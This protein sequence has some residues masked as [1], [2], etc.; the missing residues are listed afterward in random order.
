MP[1]KVVD[2][3]ET[4]S[5]GVGGGGANN[6][7]SGSYVTSKTGYMLD[8]NQFMPNQRLTYIVGVLLVSET[9]LGCCFWQ[10][11]PRPS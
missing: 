2:G 3:V 1:R 11:G 6:A 4:V 8:D 9:A 10:I 7:I 5:R